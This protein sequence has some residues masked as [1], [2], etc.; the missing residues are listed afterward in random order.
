[1]R[2]ARSLLTVVATLLAVAACSEGSTAP[3]GSKLGD[4]TNT[5]AP[6]DT[7]TTGVPLPASVRVHGRVLVTTKDGPR[8]PGDTLSAFVPLPGSRVTLYR[9]V[10]VDGRGVSVKLAEQVVGDDGAF[11]FRNVPGGYY[12]LALNVTPDAF[13]GE[14]YVLVA[15]T[16]S[17]VTADIR[18]YRAVP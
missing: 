11:D 1:M 8:A 15:G 9:N 5:Q 4:K 18:L 3:D 13:Y 10:L 16:T 17:D 12:V 6:G 7:L 2:A 14:T